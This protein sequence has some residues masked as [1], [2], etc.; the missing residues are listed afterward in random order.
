MATQFVIAVY[1]EEKS[2][3]GCGRTGKKARCFSGTV[4]IVH[5]ELL[6]PHEGIAC[7]SGYMLTPLVS[8][9]IL[10][11]DQIVSFV[12]ANLTSFVE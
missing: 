1:T 7:E 4:S 5:T 3:I 11:R 2:V 10:A 9:C 12:L 6:A 8:S